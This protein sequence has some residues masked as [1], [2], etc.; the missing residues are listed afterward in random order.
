MGT[1][2][3][4][5]NPY[6]GVIFL[7]NTSVG[8]LQPLLLPV[9]IELKATRFPTASIVHRHQGG[10]AVT[11]HCRCAKHSYLLIQ[12]SWSDQRPNY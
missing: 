3:I 12:P 4:F 7:S 6:E 2:P 9:S 10:Y 8:C 5:F 1:Y 11:Y